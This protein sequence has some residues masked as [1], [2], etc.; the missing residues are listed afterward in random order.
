MR[1]HMRNQIGAAYRDYT[2]RVSDANMS[3]SFKM[4]TY[5]WDT[6]QKLKPHRI[7]DLGS[8][9][10][11][12]VFRLY[13]KK[14]R[15]D[16]VVFSVDTA[17]KWLRGTEKFLLKHDLDTERLV[18][19]K[20]LAKDMPGGFDLVLHDLADIRRR[21]K[22]MNAVA[23]A[24]KPGALIVCDDAHKTEY[25]AFLPKWAAKHG[26]KLES[27]QGETLDDLGRCAVELWK[28]GR[29]GE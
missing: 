26:W 9:F 5:L 19:W 28:P 25:S 24:A 1:T 20:N 18:L 4:V 2:S 15:H 22:V 12:F 11:S 27:L 23:E 8:G 7:L 29:E 13:A 17:K 21:M 3:I 16:V 14:S 6:I 10:S